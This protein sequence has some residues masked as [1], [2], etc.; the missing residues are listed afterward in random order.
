M[1]WCLWKPRISNSQSARGPAGRDKQR[2]RTSATPTTT[3]RCMPGC[4]PNPLALARA[5][6]PHMHEQHMR[7]RGSER[8]RQAGRHPGSATRAPPPGHAGCTNPRA[9]P[10]PPR[11]RPRT[12]SSPHARSSSS[13]ISLSLHPRAGG[14][15]P[16]WRCRPS[17]YASLRAARARPPTTRR[18]DRSIYACARVV[19]SPVASRRVR[20]ELSW[21]GRALLSRYAII[22]MRRR[23]ARA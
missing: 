17:R 7:A 5:G 15:R 16:I 2:R 1:G 12:S 13:R 14:P 10:A 6:A 23:L 21:G 4:N 19:S 22:H 3:G 18:V 8:G 9:C 20:A 11:P